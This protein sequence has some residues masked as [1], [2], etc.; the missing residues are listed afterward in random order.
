[1]CAHPWN[2]QAMSKFGDKCR[3]KKTLP[4]FF[5]WIPTLVGKALEAGYNPGSHHLITRNK[6]VEA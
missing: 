3:P 5:Q 1:M 4:I 6:L 2:P